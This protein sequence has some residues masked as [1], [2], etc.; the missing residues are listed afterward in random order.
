VNQNEFET[1]VDQQT[2][3]Q[4]HHIHIID[5][6]GSMYHEIDN[7]IDNLQKTLDVISEND[8]L[9][10][11][12][13][14]SPN[15]YKTVIKAAKKTDNLKQLFDSMRSVMGCT[16][17][18]HPLK[19]VE[20]IIGDL[21][22]LCPNFNV[23][24]FTDGL[25][26][27][28]WG[29]EVEKNNIREIL[30][31]LQENVMSINTIGYGSNCDDK[32][33]QEISSYS[34]FGQFVHSEHIEEYL[35]IF[36]HNYEKISESVIEK[37]QIATS[38][39]IVYLNRKMSKMFKA[40]KINFN[41][42]AKDKNQ[43][44]IVGNSD[45]VF[46]YN[47]L[48]INSKDI[49]TEASSP[50]MDNFLYAYAYNLFVEG[51]RNFAM[52][53][54][55]KTLNDKHCVDQI[56]NCFTPIEIEAVRQILED[57]VLNVNSRYSQGK[58][59]N[60]YLPRKDAHCVLDI[61]NEL[62][63]NKGYYVPFH[64]HS[65]V[66]ERTTRKVEDKTKSFII[67]DEPC[68][69]SME[70]FVYHKEKLNLSIKFEVKGVVPLRK[71]DAEKVG[72]NE[73]KCS[74]FR[75]HTIILNGNINMGS[76]VCL[77]PVE[78]YDSLKKKNTK[79]E[80]LS[81]NKDVLSELKKEH[82]MTFN[83]V[84]IWINNKPLINGLY[85]DKSSSIKD[86]FNM[87]LEIASLEAKQKMIN[88]YIDLVYEKNPIAAK[89][90]VFKKLTKDQIAILESYGVNEKAWYH[91][92]EIYVPKTSEC[93]SYKVKKFEFV[94]KGLSSLPSIAEYQKAL[95][96]SKMTIGVTMMDL[97]HKWLVGLTNEAGLDIED[98]IFALRDF[99]KSILRKVKMELLSLRET[100]A[101]IKLAKFLCHDDFV[102]LS[103]DE[104]G[105]RII[106]K[107]DKI[108]YVKTKESLEYI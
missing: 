70:D 5:R 16:C 45:F 99:L 91:P 56:Q 37:V 92:A 4:I 6:S 10:V 20:E 59:P 65:D 23:T 36:T 86:I 67:S 30:Q 26:C 83:C 66:Y 60:N 1:V 11:I 24:L 95:G 52:N 74:T 7:L 69:T 87:S 35:K 79:M 63:T 101:G 105:N 61:L 46:K 13:F 15:Q 25:P 42:L 53:I 32:L 58:C 89:E 82:G 68:Y 75:T 85:L 94:F 72:M 93:D 2:V 80:F 73:V 71:D 8:L 17:F 108:L 103:T 90:G 98:P 18:S 34:E 104:K 77:I 84:K 21:K 22:V 81:F 55:G 29:E 40:P 48:Q 39:P 64:K 3:D 76:L 62:A 9:S 57:C 47:D 27:V 78:I 54:Y 41:R 38:F 50:T 49:I 28:S 19:E 44:F 100:M 12:W 51:Q 107:D 33:L 14:S 96:K 102:G 106:E 88:H 43:F 31:R 97:A